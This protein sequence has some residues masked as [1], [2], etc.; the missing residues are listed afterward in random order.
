MEF[1]GYKSDCLKKNISQRW[2][3]DKNVIASF[4]V[5]SLLIVFIKKLII[6]SSC[7]LVFFRSEFWKFNLEIRMI[8][9]T[10]RRCCFVGGP[11]GVGLFFP[12]KVFFEAAFLAAVLTFACWSFFFLTNNSASLFT[13][14]GVRCLLVG[15]VTG[16]QVDM[17]WDLNKRP[18][19]A[20]KL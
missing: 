19:K 5:F 1:C 16:F 17:L 15:D 10:W 4:I 7:S 18:R 13:L 12:S 6:W 14:G 11:S 20:W 9:I 2:D 8:D 3:K